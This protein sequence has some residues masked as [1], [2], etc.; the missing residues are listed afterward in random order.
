MKRFLEVRPPM[1]EECAQHREET[2][3]TIEADRDELSV[4]ICVV[5]E[6]EVVCSCTMH[7]EE[8][9]RLVAE[10]ELHFNVSEKWSMK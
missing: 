8:W 7:V 3:L 10:F 2:G 9:R 6:G 5:E 4:A 1:D